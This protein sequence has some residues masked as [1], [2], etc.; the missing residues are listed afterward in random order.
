MIGHEG[1]KCKNMRG[2]NLDRKIGFSLHGALQH[3]IFF[4][5]YNTD[6]GRQP[7]A[8]LIKFGI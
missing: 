1:K 3:S 7:F 5:A 2:L 8:F 6:N 4:L